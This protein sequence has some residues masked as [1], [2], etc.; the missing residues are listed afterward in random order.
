MSCLSLPL[1]HFSRDVIF[2]SSLWTSCCSAVLGD[3]SLYDFFPSLCLSDLPALYSTSVGGSL[4]RPI[5]QYFTP[6][7]QWGSV[8]WNLVNLPPW[9]LVLI[10]CVNTVLLGFS[11]FDGVSLSMVWDL[12]H[13]LSH[14]QERSEGTSDCYNE[15]LWLATQCL[16]VDDSYHGCVDD[17]LGF[18]NREAAFACCASGDWL[19]LMTR[20]RYKW[21]PLLPVHQPTCYQPLDCV[22]LG[23]LVPASNAVMI[24]LTSA[25]LTFEIIGP[26]SEDAVILWSLA[27]A[28][29]IKPTS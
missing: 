6:S 17:A 20:W 25:I 12:W 14:G 4:W 28:I 11:E 27:A 8:S 26:R 16:W 2:F 1:S 3:T 18:I 13:S 22:L 24:I 9:W 21:L 19:Q 10:F 15:W 5:L 23:V 7:F 29:I